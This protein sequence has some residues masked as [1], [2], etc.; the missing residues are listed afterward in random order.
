MNLLAIGFSTI[1][2][3]L[4]VPIFMVFGLGSSASA[5]WGLN[6]PWSTLIQVAFGSMTKHVLIAVPLFI[7]TGM[8]M[9]RGGAAARLVGFATALVGHWP[10]G[11]GIA[12]VIAMG[13]FAAFCGSILAAITAVGT[14][15]MPKMIEQGYPKPFV[16]V[17][18]ASAA[19]L[20]SLIPPSNAAIL[21]SALT[22][23]P[24][25]RTFA[26][27]MIPGLILLVLMS[28]VV[29]WKCRHLRNPVRSSGSEKL[30]AFFA[31]IPALFSPVII[32]GGIYAGL[33]TPSESAAMAGVWALFIG[34]FVYRELTI[35]GLM[36]CL[37][38]TAKITAVIFAIIAMATFL[39]VVL[40]YTQAPQKI[41]TYFTELGGTPM[42]FWLAVA[43]ICLILG[44]FVEIVP[45][46]YLTVPIFAALALSLGLD[47]LHLYVVF[48]AFAGIGMITPPVCV[49]VYTAAGVVRE[50]P[51][52]AF[53]EVPL[54]ILVGIVF[55]LILIFLPGSATWLPSVLN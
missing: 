28:A 26:A 16:I 5:I 37:R 36:E 38:Q 54:F 22:D 48:V 17:L 33:L 13:F 29:M 27:G 1:L 15:M 12:M 25:D 35:G 53:R 20:E 51:E 55:G 42:M 47:V 10:G 31:S 49:G 52:K 34:F 24:V 40:T 2:L 6:L 46:F 43:M 4:S 50:S 7:F 14:I 11:L 39:S 18:A 45:V 30:N 19:L 44:T 23:V 8:A 21:F 9:L 41:I 3:F 32:L